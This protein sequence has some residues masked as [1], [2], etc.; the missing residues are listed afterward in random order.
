MPPGLRLRPSQVK[1]RKAIP[2]QLCPVA[3]QGRL[4]QKTI[5][6]KRVRDAAWPVIIPAWMESALTAGGATSQTVRR[7][8]AVLLI[9]PCGCRRLFVIAPS[10]AGGRGESSHSSVVFGCRVGLIGCK[11]ASKRPQQCHL[12]LVPHEMALRNPLFVSPAETSHAHGRLMSTLSGRTSAVPSEGAECG[13]STPPCGV[14]TSDIH[15]SKIAAG[16]L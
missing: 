14:L 8:K 6:N 7:Q 15:L 11:S 5:Q 3:S 13:G 1:C 10:H 16:Q 4:I 12:A 2:E 9:T